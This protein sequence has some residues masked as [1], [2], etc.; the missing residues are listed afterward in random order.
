MTRKPLNHDRKRKKSQID[1]NIYIS[2]KTTRKEIRKMKNTEM[3]KVVANRSG[4]STEVCEAVVKGFEKAAEYALKMKFK[5]IPANDEEM[6][7]KTSEY[8]GVDVEVCSRVIPVME[9]TLSL[10]LTNKLTFKK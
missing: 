5:G 1:V 6:A 3:I 7:A 2:N 4:E 9:E 10:N 8:S